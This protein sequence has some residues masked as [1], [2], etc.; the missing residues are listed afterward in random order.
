MYICN[1]IRALIVN[2]IYNEFDLFCKPT[3]LHCIK[4]YT[5]ICL[6]KWIS[7]PISALYV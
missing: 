5:F 7:V 2:I 4:H 1:H 3:H 6:Y